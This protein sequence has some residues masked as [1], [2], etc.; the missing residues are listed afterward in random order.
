[1]TDTLNVLRNAERFIA[2]FEGDELQEGIPELLADMRLALISEL[3]KRKAK[4][5][6]Q[7]VQTCG[8]GRR[9]Q[10]QEQIDAIAGELEELA[11]PIKA[12]IWASS[13][14]Y[15]QTNVDFYQVLKIKGDW[16]TLQKI[17]KNETSDG[18]LSM[19]GRV[20]PAKPP[21]PVGDPFR[22]KIFHS[23]GEPCA[24]ISSY[25]FARPWDGKPERVSHYA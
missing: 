22:R 20:V 18:A 6:E 4:L 16:I 14:G 8:H 17:G 2:G 11:E 24:K 15:E 13:W 19:T 1:M 3:V 5:I 7:R 9:A 10:I 12:E 25:A 21:L 23:C